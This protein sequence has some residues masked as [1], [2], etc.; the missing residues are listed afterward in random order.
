[1]RIIRGKYKTRKYGIPKKFPSRPT[2][3]YAKEGLFNVLMHK[4]ELE[5]L[6]I[7]DLCAGTGS[8]SIEFLSR[9]A[10]SV[11]AVDQNYN[12]V[13]H[14]KAMAERFECT[15]D[16]V[17]Y[18]QEQLRFLEKT[19]QKFDLIFSDPPYEYSHHGRIAELVFERE[20]LEEDG[21]LIIEHGKQTD[22]SGIPYYDCSR[23]YGNVHFS[24]FRIKQEDE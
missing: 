5:D 8:I 1:M 9:E 24:F 16:L 10:G 18:K 17:V 2:T 14:I 20:L 13:R 12:C 22:C 23:I 11:V 6:K 21:L 4:M 15:D 3:D 7:L 19:T